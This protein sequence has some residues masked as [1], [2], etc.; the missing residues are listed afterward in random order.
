MSST[1][2][3]ILACAAAGLLGI[4]GLD[5]NQQAAALDRSVL[6]RYC[7]TCHNERLKT[8]GLMLDKID[9]SQL[10]GQAPVLE[11]VILKLRSGQM[12]PAGRPRPDEAA[13]DTFVTALE[14][15]LD[16][17]AS[18]NPGRVAA[19]RLNRLE[20]VTAVH[21]L[22]ALD[23][24]PS[25]L[26]ADSPGVG[27]DNNADALSVTPSLMNRYMAAASKVSRLAIGDPSITP[28]IQVYQT[29]EF[30]PQDVRVSED[31][32]FG[33]HGG[34]TVRHAFPLDGEY[35]FKL[36]MQRNTI[37]D[38]IRGID[39][40]QEIEVRIDHVL[41][42]RFT[43]GGK[44]KGYDPGLVNGA[45]EDDLEGQKLH[46]YRLTADEPLEFRLRVDAGTRLVTA[47]FT[48][49]A[50]SLSENVP[51][52]P[53]SPRRSFFTDD[54]GHPGIE[55][56]VVSG[57]Y[58]SS[59]PKDTPSRRR[60]FVCQP[61][62][63]GSSADRERCARDILSTL[64]R[65]AYRRPVTRA[66]VDELVDLYKQGSR[67][68]GFEGGI[69]LAL[70]T[71]LWSPA[72]LIRM[73]RDPG[74]AAAGTAYRLSDLELASRLSFFLWKSIPDDDLLTAAAQGRLKDPAILRAQAVRMLRDP[75]ARRW[76]DDFVGQWLTVRN[77]HGHDPD[78]DTF[79]EF[80]DGLRE[81]MAAETELFFESQVREDHGLLDLL[82]A[83][84][85]F[86]NARLAQ[87]YGVAGVYGSHF[88][89]V[90][91][92]DPARRGL[93]GHASVLTVTSYADRTSVVLRGK[94]VLEN[95]L[96]A[97]PPPPPANVPPLPENARG[98]PPK[99]LRERMEQ[100]RASPVC[101][102]CHASMDPLGFALEN[103]DAT[104]RW[105]ETDAGAPIDAVSTTAS[106][107][108]VAGPAGF[109][110]YLLGRHD[111]FVSTL[112][113]KLLEYA[114]GRSLEYYDEPV[115]RRLVRDASRT[116]YR[117]SSLILGIVESVP[118]QMRSVTQM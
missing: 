100:H 78:P 26:P 83:D 64:A 49:R 13:V 108:K 61:A 62:T 79:R 1:S 113:K 116:D 47:A 52:V 103:F 63:G 42:Q 98:A 48:D 21:D 39:D 20:Y 114:I 4:I 72:F 99:S 67:D 3:I 84:Y 35:V 14:N 115:V 112:T 77:I 68:G 8:A 55:R 73:E 15:S 17:A 82:R 33:T 96:G 65:R 54:A 45:P 34:L 76:M 60:I 111:E 91:V 11:K 107:M 25:L 87:H 22:L 43:V 109:R 2:R 28:T 19:H 81:A 16:R 10:A 7:V 27:F 36:R 88:R 89:K 53:A 75:K 118:F 9:L 70:E 46:T 40:E 90:T 80:D 104:G 101:A 41:T 95:L 32:P 117:W 50:P 37:G 69:G 92:T 110:E 97:P 102:T 94:W 12:P 29:S 66:D 106:G 30:A 38:T 6:D 59:A 56:I 44:Y 57:P 58:T 105:R 18:P 24:D 71:L 5:A 23:I 74:G 85:T 31:A 93:L 86:L 51:L